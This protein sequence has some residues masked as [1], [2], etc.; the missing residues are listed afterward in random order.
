MMLV[1]VAMDQVTESQCTYLARYVKLC[2]AKT[3]SNLIRTYTK[4]KSYQ[5]NTPIAQL[6]VTIHISPSPASISLPH[7][8]DAPVMGHATNNILSYIS[9]SLSPP[10]IIPSVHP[11]IQYS[12]V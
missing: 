3:P 11:S 2:Q 8:S 7:F 9:R 6:F 4:T 1:V 5:N 10:S 12:Y